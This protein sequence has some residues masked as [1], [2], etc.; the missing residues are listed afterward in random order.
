MDGCAGLA[1]VGTAYSCLPRAP[2]DTED[3]P[4]VDF[5]ATGG[6]ASISDARQWLAKTP[7]RY[8]L[9]HT[10]TLKQSSAGT[11]LGD[12]AVVLFE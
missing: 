2:E 12:G 8:A 4:G 10:A 1:V 9:Q 11:F 6:M 5:V 3:V 7:L